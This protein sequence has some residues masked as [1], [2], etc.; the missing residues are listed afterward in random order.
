MVVQHYTPDAGD[1]VWINLN[2]TKGHE[3]GNLR[4]ALV[5]SPK[6]YN[7][8]SSLVVVCPVTS[9]MKGYPFEVFFET[10]KILGSVLSDHMR[11]LDWRVR[12]VKFICKA[13]GTVL[14]EVREKITKLIL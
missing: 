1:F 5:L 2:P 4:P 14:A 13:P 3:Q 11:A 7:K 10:K 6:T 8:K 9:K 12:P